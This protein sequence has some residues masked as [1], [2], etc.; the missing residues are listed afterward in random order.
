M[1]RLRPVRRLA[2]ARCCW[3]PP[4]RKGTH[5]RSPSGHRSPTPRYRLLRFHR[6]LLPVHHLHHLRHF[7]LL[8]L[9]LRLHL[10]LLLHPR[11]SAGQSW[12]CSPSLRP[13][14]SA[15]CCS[16]AC[17]LQLGHPDH[18]RWR[19]SRSY[20][21][22]CGLLRVTRPVPPPF[23]SHPLSPPSPS[24]PPPPPLL[25]PSSARLLSPSPSPP[26]WPPHAHSPRPLPPLCGRPDP[27]AWRSVA[28][29]GPRRRFCA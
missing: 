14:C 28:R 22:Q 27:A 5:P 3:R 9:L 13:G 7:H 29:R 16:Y 2:R 20:A 11:C 23:P 26:P 15:A 18:G 8:H 1:R 12:L 4:Q 17:R 6:P 24:P 10:L 19:V 25:L 21:R